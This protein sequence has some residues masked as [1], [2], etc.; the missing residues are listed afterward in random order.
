VDDRGL[1]PFF[2]A[3]A[4]DF[5]TIQTQS[6]GEWDG[7]STDLARVEH[8][9]RQAVDAVRLWR[10]FAAD[11]DTADLL[12][13]AGGWKGSVG[14]GLL[15]SRLSARD[16]PLVLDV[17]DYTEW[18]EQVP[19]VFPPDLAD[20][21]IASNGPLARRIGGE[22]VYTP[23]DTDRF[24]PECHDG[25]AV[26]AEFGFEPD[27]FVAGFIGTPRPTKG[28]HTLVE[29]VGRTEDVHGLV[30]GAPDG[31]EYTERLRSAADGKTRVVPPVPHSEVPAYYAAIDALVL[32]QQR[33]PFCEYQ[34]PAKLF[35]AMSMARPVVATAIGDIPSVLG[36]TGETFEEPSPDAIV[37][38]LGRVR[39]ARGGCDAARQRAVDNYSYAVVGDQLRDVLSGVITRG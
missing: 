25:A 33:T 19:L 27:D 7:E 21:V 35:E 28:V 10:R 5:R 23:V 4:F 6:Y 30:V 32:A 20:A 11:T 37:A 3:E 8:L 36:P 12:Y 22:T 14:A 15:A 13:V 1:H 9:G 24:D 31:D 34:I 26:R 38:A 39:D 16:A 2:D 29:A 17:Y 18:F